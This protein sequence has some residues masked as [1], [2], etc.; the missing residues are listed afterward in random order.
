MF[1][2]PKIAL[3]S[4]VFLAGCAATTGSD[5]AK[6]ESKSAPAAKLTDLELAKGGQRLS[7][8]EVK[9]LIAGATIRGSNQN[10]DFYMKFA[11]D[12]T[13][14]G[15]SANYRGDSNSFSGDWRIDSDG[16]AC[17]VNRSLA[18]SQ[19]RC[20]VYYG[21]NTKYYAGANSSEG[22]VLDERNFTR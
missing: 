18:G 22:T 3:L 9:E 4:W 8:A 5:I 21:L 2:Y 14:R 16:R 10:G 7:A 19:E 6:E 15:H 13:F 11:P 1:R 20:S 17:S 12:G